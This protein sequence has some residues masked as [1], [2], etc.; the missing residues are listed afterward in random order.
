MLVS[1]Y[2]SRCCYHFCSYVAALTESLIY[3]FSLFSFLSTWL[4]V[5]NRKWNFFSPSV[6][7]IHRMIL[8]CCRTHSS[9]T[10][11]VSFCRKA[12]ISL[13]GLRGV[14]SPAGGKNKT[15]IHLPAVQK[16][17]TEIKP[18]TCSCESPEWRAQIQDLPEIHPP[19][20]FWINLTVWVDL[21]AAADFNVCTD[22]T[23]NRPERCKS[24]RIRVTDGASTPSISHHC[25]STST[26]ELNW[27]W[28]H[29]VS[30]STCIYVFVCGAV[31]LF[32][33]QLFFSSFQSK[34]L[35]FLI[36]LMQ[37]TVLCF[38]LNWQLDQ[39]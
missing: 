5:L 27:H 9:N 4:L 10:M 21:P 14:Q 30:K 13:C 28:V 18:V 31:C 7:W 29:E 19:V 23:V 35:L 36:L 32:S 2:L 39:L 26:S 3:L 22:S 6:F 34:C 17:L 33:K 37:R 1:S 12:F 25:W 11:F 16:E 38:R 15:F 8:S 20:G 24:A